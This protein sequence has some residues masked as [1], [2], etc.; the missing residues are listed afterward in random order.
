M[1]VYVVL[2]TALTPLLGGYMARAFR[3]ERVLLTGVLGPLER[4][5]HRVLRVSPGQGQDWKG[6]G[7]SVIIF[8][9]LFWLALYGIL[10]TQ[11]IHPFNPDGLDSGTWDV[12]F[13]AV[14]SFFTNTNWQFYGGETTMSY[15]SQMAGLAVQKFVSAG[16]GIAVAI[17]VI[18]GFAA[19]GAADL[20]N[21]W[22]DLPGRCSTCCCRSRSWPRC[23]SC[24]AGC[25][26]RWRARSTSRR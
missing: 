4:L 5:T 17:A 14:S 12:S 15:F 24:S 25:R 22:V 8:T 20:G 11:E 13:N 2:L 1:L 6:Y 7:R 16:V 3:G 26:R 9:L 18:R 21:F 19:R 10:R 23:C